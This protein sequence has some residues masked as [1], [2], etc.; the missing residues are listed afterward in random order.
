MTFD[1]YYWRGARPADP[2]L[3]LARERVAA[4]KDPEAFSR[5]LHSRDPVAVGIALDQYHRAEAETRHGTA[6]PFTAFTDEVAARAREI[7]RGLPSH[8][9]GADEGAGHASALGA[10]MNL[11][12]PE[13]ASL[14]ADTFVWARTANLRFAAALAA[15]GALE[16]AETPDARLIAALVRLVL[17]EASSL[18]ERQAA[19]A[20]LGRGRSA[21]TI[22]AL[23]RATQVTNLG[24]QASAALHL[25]ELD[26]VNHRA[27]VEEVVASWPAEPPY[28]ANE[29][30]ELLAETHS[31]RGEE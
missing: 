17:D 21:A 13:D 24:L 10:L 5:L 6:H 7:L 4:V 27:H 3:E 22:E 29:V 28:P 12:E 2:A 19:L 9:E 31:G 11:T 23:V 25:L 26:P 1:S 15:G 30:L 8:V 18:D 16:G 14:I 20:A